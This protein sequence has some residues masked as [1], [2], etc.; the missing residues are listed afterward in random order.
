[1]RLIQVA[2]LPSVIM[3]TCMCVHCTSTHTPVAPPHLFVQ[4]ATRAGEEPGNE[5]H[6]HEAYT[7]FS[8]PSQTTPN[9]RGS[10]CTTFLTCSSSTSES[11]Q[12]LF[13]P[14]SSQSYS[15]SSMSVSD[16]VWVCGWWSGGL[17]HPGS[18]PLCTSQGWKVFVAWCHPGSSLFALASSG[19]KIF[20]SC[21]HVVWVGGTMDRNPQLWPL[22]CGCGSCVQF[23]H[24]YQVTNNWTRCP[25]F[26]H[27]TD[28]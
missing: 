18:S 8:S 2:H 5:A 17:V 11:C 13:S 21:L 20:V 4:Q 22:S 12:S 3:Y 1:M 14:P 24:S 10:Q 6:M 27:A 7:P 15:S 19:R 9:T 23:L 25:G 26:V 16:G 28:G